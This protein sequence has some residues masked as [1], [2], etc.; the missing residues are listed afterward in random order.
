M[1]K[2]KNLQNLMDLEYELS[3]YLDY[4]SKDNENLDYVKH[5]TR[6]SKFGKSFIPLSLDYDPIV[7]GL[8]G[9]PEWPGGSY[10][11]TNNQIIISFLKQ[12]G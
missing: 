11:L 1:K 3:S 8:H 4:I 2:V 5:R 12:R 6:N 7:M 9:G 10:D